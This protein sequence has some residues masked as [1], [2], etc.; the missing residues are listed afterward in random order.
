LLDAV[1]GTE[2]RWDT[3]YSLMGIHKRFKFL[4][5]LRHM[6]SMGGFLDPEV[7]F[8]RESDSCSSSQR[9]DKH[10]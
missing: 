1:S 9:G 4:G 6:K 10:Y 2:Q 5:F 8:P 3:S 7:E